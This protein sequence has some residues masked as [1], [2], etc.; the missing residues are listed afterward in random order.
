MTAS[1]LTNLIP[2]MYAAL[3]T[4]SRERMGMVL[5]VTRNATADRVAINQ[6][7]NVPVVGSVSSVT[8]TPANVSPDSGSFTPANV[9]ITISNQKMVPIQWQGEEQAHVKATN[10]YDSIMTQRFQQAFRTIANE[11]ENDLTGLHIYSSRAYGTA[12]TTP[13]GTAGDLSD[14]AETIRILDDNGAPDDYQCVLGSAAI[15]KL[16]GKQNSL[17]KVNE[18]GTDDLLRR[19]ILGDLEGAAIRQ[20]NKI[21]RAVTVGTNS[22]ATTNAAGYAIG[23]VTITLASAGT[24]TIIA[25]DVITFAGDTNKYVVKTGD[26]D[27]SNGGTIV[28]QEP[29]LQQAIA[30]SATAITTVAA[31]TRNMLFSRSAIL[32]AAR[33]PYM[34]EGGDDADDVMDLLDPVSGLTFQIA[35]YKQYRQIHIEVG[36]AWGVKMLQPRHSAL[37]LG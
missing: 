15:A 28:L 27:V 19:G 37:L 10:I 29:G 35:M 3:D 13:F 7:V 9:D 34:P 30:A 24:G 17:F 1:T 12:A 2:N 21:R 31:A 33:Q 6:T 25:G 8:I 22:G 14:L 5:A 26:T 32:L 11:V 20:S 16:R 36:L 4:V 18:S 23:D